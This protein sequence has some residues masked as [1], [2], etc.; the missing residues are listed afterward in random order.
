[1]IEKEGVCFTETIDGL[2]KV[3]IA[4]CSKVRE[5]Y[6]KILEYYKKSGNLPSLTYLMI[7]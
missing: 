6:N 1:M 7:I 5:A 4:I 2:E 3:E